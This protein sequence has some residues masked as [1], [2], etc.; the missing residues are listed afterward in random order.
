MFDVPAQVW[1]LIAI[2]AIAFA[3]ARYVFRHLIHSP[4]RRDITLPAEDL[5]WRTTADFIRSLTILSVLGGLA[6]F[7]FTSTAEEFAQSPRLVPILAA[8]FG[9]WALFTV[10]LGFANGRIELLMKGF[11]DTFERHSHPNRFW[12]SMGWNA[13][14]GFLMLWIALQAN[15]DATAEIVADNCIQAKDIQQLEQQLSACDEFVR[16]Q[17]NDPDAYL[18]RGLIF[19]EVGWLDQ[20]VADFTRAHQL[21]PKDPWAI[22]NRGVA[23]AGRNRANAEADFELVRSIDPSNP[24]MLRGEALLRKNAGDVPG[25][26]ERLSASLNRDPDNLW[27]LR[28]RSELYWELGEQEKSIRDD[29]RW[30]QLNKQARNLRN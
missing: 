2:G 3:P 17:P 23:W 9:A 6:I 20:A 27:A 7:I 30:V 19:L 4:S 21:A 24:V 14:L 25:A 8:V 22:A 26:V 28:L 11:Y 13:S 1:I 15:K 29:R 16:R 18:Y 10:A 5:S 12:A